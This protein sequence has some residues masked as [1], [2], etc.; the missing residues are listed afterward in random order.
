MKRVMNKILTQVEVV[1]YKFH[2]DF[3]GS[4]PVT[5][6]WQAA[7]NYLRYAKRYPD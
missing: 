3:P 6:R 7:I 5:S 4:E 1:V 2:V